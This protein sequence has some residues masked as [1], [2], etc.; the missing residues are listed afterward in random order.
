MKTK[1][2][3]DAQLAL[4]DISK[5]VLNENFLDVFNGDYFVGLLS[6]MP[7][8][9]KDGWEG[10]GELFNTPGGPFLPGIKNPSITTGG[11]AQVS[12]NRSKFIAPV[13]VNTNLGLSGMVAEYRED[14]VFPVATADWGQVRGLVVYAANIN[15]IKPLFT[16]EFVSS[17]FVNF[18]DQVTIPDTGNTRIRA[19]ELIKKNTI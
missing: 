4:L 19:I 5:A 6:S 18:E 10:A 9:N 2:L 1:Y 15:R 11:Y 13:L 8:E 17:A 16:V 3:A 12:I 7:F 14:I